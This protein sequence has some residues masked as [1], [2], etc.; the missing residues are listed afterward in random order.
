MVKISR[1][2]LRSYLLHITIGYFNDRNIPPATLDAYIDRAEQIRLAAT[3]QGDMAW[4][5]LGLQHVLADKSIDASE[6]QGP[7]Y[8][9]TDPEMRDIMGYVLRTLWPEEQ[10]D[11]EGL[12]SEVELVDVALEDWP[13]LRDDQSVPT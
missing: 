13:K 7:R 8:P 11:A 9:F 1:Q 4:L 12:A 3:N 5:K 10:T 6:Y 2:M